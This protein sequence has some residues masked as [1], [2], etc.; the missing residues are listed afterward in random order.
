[1]KV[2][3]IRPKKITIECEHAE[4]FDYLLAMLPIDEKIL[5]QNQ[6]DFHEPSLK[7]A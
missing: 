4:E 7:E 6:I 2:S 5:E 1:M 3:A